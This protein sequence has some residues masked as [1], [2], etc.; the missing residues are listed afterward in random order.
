MVV[1]CVYAALGR[2]SARVG[3]SMLSSNV[4]SLSH[5]FFPCFSYTEFSLVSRALIPPVLDWS[6]SIQSSQKR[7]RFSL[8]I[9]LSDWIIFIALSLGSLLFSC[10]LQSA[11]GPLR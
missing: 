11:A 1:S 3:T 7:L 6:M 4:R 10:F 2:G 8:I 9:F 5:R